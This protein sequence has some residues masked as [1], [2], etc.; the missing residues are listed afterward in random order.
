M[1]NEDDII[2]YLPNYLNTKEQKALFDELNEFPDNIDTRLYS[3]K[4][5]DNIIY[6][7]DGL[8]DL[9]IVDLTNIEKGIKLQKCII[10]SNTCDMDIANKRNFTPSIIYAPI[11]ALSNYRRYLEKN[12]I[13]KEKI[14]SH[15]VSIKKQFITQILFLPANNTIEDSLVFLDR[16]QNI[17][18]R[19]ISRK[20][21]EERRLFTLSNYGFY[22][23]IYKLSIHFLRI[24]ERVHRN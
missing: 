10:L 7:G 20:T 5:D 15:I 22:L 1:M 2:K 8:K 18:Y 13:D 6:Q 21:L 17:D 16:I 9:P 4:L 12:K 24:Q 11:I 3:N 14:K 23:F 19:Y